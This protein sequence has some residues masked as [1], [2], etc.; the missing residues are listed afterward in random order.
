ML[1]GGRG[2]L[3]ALA[4]HVPVRMIPTWGRASL[5]PPPPI[6]RRLAASKDIPG[7]A[8]GSELPPRGPL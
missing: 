4:R 5:A 2:G 8:S 6:P 3:A 1:L 7:R